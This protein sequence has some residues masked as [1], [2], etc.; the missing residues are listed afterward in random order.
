MACG[1]ERRTRAR[2]VA[3][4]NPECP[5]TEDERKGAAAPLRIART[6][7]G[8][9]TQEFQGKTAFVTGAA[10]GIGFAMARAFGREGA[11]IV[12]ADIDGDGARY[13][14]EHLGDQ[15]KAIG[16]QCDVSERSAIERAALET[17]A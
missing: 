10:S 2:D 9:V 5:S 8:F 7:E 13:A 1:R 11:N 16:V 14:A 6:G 17:I 15:I 3:R 12:A 4:R